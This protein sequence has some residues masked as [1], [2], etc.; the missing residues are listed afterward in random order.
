MPDIVTYSYKEGVATIAMDDGKANA[1]GTSVWAELNAALDKAEEK[2]AIVA[3][4]T[5]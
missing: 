3:L 4:K 5:L 2:N 1:L